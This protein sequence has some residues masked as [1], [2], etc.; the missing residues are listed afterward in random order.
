[1]PSELE[2]AI[3]QHLM[4]YLGGRMTLTDFEDWFL[5][6]FWD[7]DSEDEQT[8]EMAG[9][10]HILIS[11]FSRGDRTVDGLQRGLA[12]TIRT[13]AENR[14]GEMGQRVESSAILVAA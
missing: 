4:Q 14:Y 5:P 11:E 2:L 12:E 13:A 10:V 1:M 6:V 3:Q 9:T 7:V 8:R